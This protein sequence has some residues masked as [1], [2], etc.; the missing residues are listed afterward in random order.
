ME[1]ELKPPPAKRR[2][3]IIQSAYVPWKGFFD[4]INRCDEYVILRFGSVLERSLA[5]S[6]PNQ[7]AA[8]IDMDHNSGRNGG[9][10]PTTD[11]RRDY[12]E[13]VG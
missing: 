6:Q 5:Q 12:S 8:R 4:L 7:N 10:L 3:S 1:R 13:A 9:P 2:I 11:P